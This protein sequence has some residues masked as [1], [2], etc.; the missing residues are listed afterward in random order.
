[1][2]GWLDRS[3]IVVS[4][5]KEGPK[6]CGPFVANQPAKAEDEVDHREAMPFGGM[7]ENDEAGRAD[8]GACQGGLTQIVL[9]CVAWESRREHPEVRAPGRAET[10]R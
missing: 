8:E 3:G 9:F 7:L 1:M 10:L 6:Q 2:Q 5:A 4:I